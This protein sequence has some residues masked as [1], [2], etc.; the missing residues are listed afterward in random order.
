MTTE[1]WKQVPGHPDY[2]V[3]DLGRMKSYR[4]NPEGKLMRAGAD[5]QGYHQVKLDK[6]C[7]RV[8]RLVAIAFLGDRTNEGLVVAHNSGDKSDNRLEN[9]RW[10][11]AKENEADKLKHG[12]HNRGERKAGSKLKEIDV[13][14]A[15]FLRTEGLTYQAIAD[16]LGISEG[17][18]C[19]IVRGTKWSH[20]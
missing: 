7:Y 6:K 9:L 2:E 1:Q 4:R 11:T 19:E 14:I 15:R 5:R 18:A 3:S 16:K 10:A 13:R 8:H 17:H 20:I 12:T